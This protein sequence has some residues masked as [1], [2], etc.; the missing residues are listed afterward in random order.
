[1]RVYCDNQSSIAL[2]KNA[3]LNERS[4]HIDIAYHHIRDLVRKARIEIAYIPT[5]K[6]VADSLTKP[7]PREAFQRGRYAMGLI[8]GEGAQR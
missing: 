5:L 2:T 8:S 4:K 3:H 6:M 1:M 7:L